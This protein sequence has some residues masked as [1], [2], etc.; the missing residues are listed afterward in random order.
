MFEPLPL[1]SF[2]RNPAS[3][4]LRVQSD[5]E[6]AFHE[7]RPIVWTKIRTKTLQQTRFDRSFRRNLGRRRIVAYVVVARKE[8]KRRW[9]WEAHRSGRI[10][11]TGVGGAIEGNV[12]QM[13]R[14]VGSRS[15][16][17]VAHCGPVCVASWSRRSQMTVSDYY[18]SHQSCCRPPERV[19]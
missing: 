12:S 3:E 1:F 5:H 10:Q 17:I 2:G 9:P 13:H 7:D 11:L 16:G 4:Q 8:S 19:S 6:P 15:G 18:N 14:Q